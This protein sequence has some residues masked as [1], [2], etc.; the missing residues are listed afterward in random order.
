MIGMDKFET[1]EEPES[2]QI[3]DLGIADYR[4]VL[5]KQMA[6]Q[7]QRKAKTIEDTVL[8]V[9]HPAVITLGARATANRLLV[10]EQILRNQGID[11]VQVRRGGGGRAA[12]W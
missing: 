6:L 3:V 1:I 12:S 2:I 5:V 4:V 9:E 11:L 10:P 8:L 7:E